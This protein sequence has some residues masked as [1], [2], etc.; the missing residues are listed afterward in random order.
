MKKILLI[1]SIISVLFLAGCNIN[2]DINN[3]LLE[4]N[5]NQNQ[6]NVQNNSEN[7]QNF[8]SIN[9]ENLNVSTINLTVDDAVNYTDA[10]YHL[11]KVRLPKVVGNTNTIKELNQKILNEVLPITY[12]DVVSHAILS[13]SLDKG[14]AYDYKYIIKD[15][16]L[17]IDIYSSVPE[18]G[19][20]VPA[21]G[22]GLQEFSYYYDVVNDKILTLSEAASK[23]SL[24]LDGITTLDGSPINSYDELEKNH[25]M[26]TII[27]NDL[28]LE[29]FN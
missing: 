15:N 12:R 18:G 21:S 23:L 5:D 8:E 17:V 14:S 19:S 16:I 28:K 27:N 20:I 7:I 3:G 22:G 2:Q 1:V 9:E 25:Y 29:F 6:E 4:N 10:Y 24:S 26:I 11:F 13:E